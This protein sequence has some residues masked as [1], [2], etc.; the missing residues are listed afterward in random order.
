MAHLY[1]SAA[2]K[3]S[4]KTTISIGLCRE[5]RRLGR[6]VQPFKKG[7]DYIDPLWLGQAAGRDCLNLDFNTTAAAEIRDDFARSLVGADLGL[8]EGNV[9]LFDSVD[10]DGSNSNAALA[11]L[12]KAPVILIVDVRGMTR[13][14]APLLLGY[15]AFDPDLDI[16]GVVFNQVG[17]SR[18]ETNL[19]RVI[20]HYTDLPLLG[21]IH[22]EPGLRIDERHLGLMPSNEAERAEEQIERIRSLV[23][24]QVDTSRLLEIADRVPIPPSMERGEP[25]ETFTG[26]SV[27]I[28]IA[29]DDAF[30][31]YYPDDLRAIRRAG[32]DLVEFSPVRDRELT[33]ADALF[34]G[35]GFPEF[36]MRELEANTSMRESIRD[37]IESGGPV[38]AECGGLMY[39]CRGLRWGDDYRRMC[40]VLNADAVMHPR[41]QGRGYVRLAE[42]DAFP[43]PRLD[44]PPGEIRA[45]E[46]HHSSL[47]E[48]DPDW[49]YGYRVLRGTGIDGKH[50][51]IVHKNL[52]ASYSHLRDVGG[53]G[54]TRRF[55]EHVRNR[56]TQTAVESTGRG[57]SDVD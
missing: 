3:S 24:S 39:L 33:A 12:L 4:G 32:A 8:V 50:D 31:F 54:W 2:H 42:T 10:L 45:H 6:R 16:A 28:A 9:G 13:G 30:G 46:F 26:L 23:A 53:V 20:D 41:P 29:R 7:P 18:H 40:G 17:G 35:G 15:Q 38:Y 57:R 25:E 55:V 44:D 47:A 36:R 56:M 37:F 51:A 19:R 14:V 49:R 43:W 34:I 5:L 22:R 11:K 1:I 48:P 21:A 27:R 52:V